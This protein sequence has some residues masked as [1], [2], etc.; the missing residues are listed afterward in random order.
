VSRRGRAAKE[1]GLDVRNDQ[2]AGCAVEPERY[3][4]CGNPGLLDG[5]SVEPWD[6]GKSDCPATS[7]YGSGS[8]SSVSTELLVGAQCGEVAGW[9]LWGRCDIWGIR[10][11]APGA[12]VG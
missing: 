5:C 1:K 9:K 4:V 2:V 6:E 10:A 11:M 7:A 8:Y 3:K 12:A